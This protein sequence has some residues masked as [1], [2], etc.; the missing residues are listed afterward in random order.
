MVG[1]QAA[2]GIMAE[3]VVAGAEVVE[4]DS[5]AEAVVSAV[6]AAAVAGSQFPLISSIPVHEGLLLRVFITRLWP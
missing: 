2:V 5:P 3:A 6:V 4:A 1:H